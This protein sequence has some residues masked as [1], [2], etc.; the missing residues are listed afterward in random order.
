MKNKAAALTFLLLSAFFLHGQTFES[1]Y[2]DLS[3]Q[4]GI[5]PNAGTKS[6]LVLMVPSGGKYEGMATAYT[7]VAGDIGFIHSNPAGSS[8]LSNSELS[9]LHNNWISDVNLESIIWATRLGNLGLGFAGK[10]MYLPFTGVNDW[11]DRY[12]NDYTNLY[13]T[14]YYWETIG[15]ANISY[16]LFRNYYFDGVSIGGSFKAGYRHVPY[17]IAPDQSAVAIMGDVGVITRFNFLKPYYSRDKNFSVGVALKNVGAEFIQNP[18]PLPMEF[19]AG[20]AYNPVRPLT[21]AFDFNLPLPVATSESFYFAAGMN[22]A[23][24]SFLSLQSGVLIK[25]GK[26]RFTIGSALELE[27]VDFVV[28]YTLDLTTQF[29]EMD[30]ISLEVRFNLGDDGRTKREEEADNLYIEGLKLYAEGDFINAIKKWESCLE[31]NPG[32][33]P[34]GDMIDT[35]RNSFNLQEE[36][37]QRQSA[38]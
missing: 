24:T 6:F 38:E 27:K 9:F 18:D 28:N 14:G 10:I 15:T 25:S 21:L 12:S 5:D 23:M 2:G 35:A 36:M 4:F 29:D 1:I 17:A 11:G 20:L 13:A 37:L 31:L 33:T 30:R 19:S 32:F 16:N 7:A 22:L 34:A 3:K 8:L 26:P